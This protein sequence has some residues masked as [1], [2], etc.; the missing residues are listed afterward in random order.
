VSRAYYVSLLTELASDMRKR[1]KKLKKIVIDTFRAEAD[2]TAE[3]ARGE[4]K[5]VA[6]E[7][8]ARGALGSGAQ[9]QA[10]LELRKKQIENS[11]NATLLR[12]T[13]ILTNRWIEWCPW[14][15]RVKKVVI[16]ALNEAVQN[17][18]YKGPLPSFAQDK[19]KWIEGEM[20]RFKV[21]MEERISIEVTSSIDS[22]IK[23]KQQDAIKY[24]FLGVVTLVLVRVILW[25][26]GL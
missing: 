2:K 8:D 24:F 20:S 23:G 25:F 16:S 15:E 13:V 9:M 21:I 17:R 7:L 1:E 12:L 18:Y 3:E 26:F 14:T 19:V 22:L 4:G 10:Y 6:G 11:I 5:R